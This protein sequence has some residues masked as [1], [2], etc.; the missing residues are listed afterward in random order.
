MLLSQEPHAI[1][2]LAGSGAR[3]FQAL[4]QFCVLRLESLDSFRIDS[5]A[6]C[7]GIERFDA[8]LSLHRA[9]SEHGKLVSKMTD[10]LLKF[11]ECLNFRTFA[12]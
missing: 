9:F 10:E 6:A 3:R 2:D 12:V 5:T 4:F 8:S 1:Q 11:V 7:S